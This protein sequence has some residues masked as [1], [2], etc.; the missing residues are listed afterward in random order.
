MLQNDL[1]GAVRAVLARFSPPWP[2]MFQN[3]V[4]GVV[5]ARFSPPPDAGKPTERQGNA[6]KH[7]KT[8]GNAGKRVGW[9]SA[10]WAGF[11]PRGL[12]FRFVCRLSLVACRLW[13]VACLL[14]LVACRLSLVACRLS[15]VVCR[16]S[17]VACRLSLVAEVPPY[18]DAQ[19]RFPF[20]CRS[21]CIR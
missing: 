19:Q 5:L 16:L 11:L 1:R 12:D 18:S 8:T 6:R 14:S 7:R 3:D 15:L 10:S 20:P 2:E 21:G 17:L 9:I 13:L 4:L